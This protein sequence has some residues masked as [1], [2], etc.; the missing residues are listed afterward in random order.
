MPLLSAA[1]AA[2]GKP[3]TALHTAALLPLMLTYC[4]AS[5]LECGLRSLITIK[6]LQLELCDLW[7]KVPNDLFLNIPLPRPRAVRWIEMILSG[8]QPHI[9][10]VLIFTETK[11]SLTNNNSTSALAGHIV[12]KTHHLTVHPFFH[13]IQELVKEPRS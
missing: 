11:A 2:N 4:K 6:R 13:I 8:H 1:V 12:S 3:V 5:Q 10:F 9:A 7:V